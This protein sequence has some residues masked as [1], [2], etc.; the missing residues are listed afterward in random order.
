MLKRKHDPDDSVEERKEDEE[1]EEDEEPV[2]DV[3]YET[4]SLRFLTKATALASSQSRI[5]YR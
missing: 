1:E 3:K 4:I 2:D 5:H